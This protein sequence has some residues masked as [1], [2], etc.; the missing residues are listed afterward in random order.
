M[1]SCLTIAGS[2]CSA[3]AGI[4]TD[5]KTFTA[6]GTYG[7]TALTCIVAEVPGEVRTI[8][9]V[10]P[11]VLQDQINIL[12]ETYRIDAIKTGMLYLRAHTVATAEILSK[13]DIPLVVDPVMVATAGIPLL[14]DK[15]IATFKDRLLPLAT[16][17]TP[18]IPEALT[19]LGTPEANIETIETM[20]HAAEELSKQ[21]NT[22]IL[23]KGGHLPESQDRTDVLYHAGNIHHFTSSSISTPHTHGTGCTLAAAITAN[24]A[25]G[26]PLP[27]AIAKAK[28]YIVKHLTDFHQPDLA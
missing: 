8:E 6:N 14:D 4:Q 3:G 17:A 24:I 1:K 2:D 27:D 12:L 9:S 13:K 22:S 20:E 26:A 18:N 23:L 19:L 10:P 11:A 7:L 28:D 15:A 25:K 16:L 21:L 5:L